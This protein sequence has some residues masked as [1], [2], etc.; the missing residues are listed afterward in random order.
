MCWLYLRTTKETRKVSNHYLRKFYS[1]G[2]DLNPDGW[3][4][5]THMAKINDFTLMKEPVNASNSMV[6]HAVG[7]QSGL[8]KTRATIA[9]VRKMSVGVVSY[10]NTQ[11]MNII[12]KKTGQPWA[13]AHN[14]TAEIN[15]IEAL[16]K[17]VA[18]NCTYKPVTDLDSERLFIEFLDCIDR[19]MPKGDESKATFNTIHE[20]FE[21]LNDYAK[22]C[23]VATNG[24]LSFAYRDLLGRR[25]LYLLKDTIGY[26]VCTKNITKAD[27]KAFLPGQLLVFKKGEIIYNSHVSKKGVAPK[28]HKFFSTWESQKGAPI[29]PSSKWDFA[30]PE[31]EYLM[32]R[33]NFHDVAEEMDLYQDLDEAT[34]SDG[35]RDYG[36][37]LLQ[38]GEDGH[39]F[40]DY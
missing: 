16:N 18:E 11:P 38:E 24:E 13:F 12:S 33:D 36:D 4:I 25:K 3:G 19:I 17:D 27:W 10:K 5:T 35:R 7:I 14:G 9:H 39:Y 30:F 40:H 2:G 31:N 26:V 34:R 8:P 28:V 37:R 21:T 20:F 32:G 6:A 29:Y 22:M 15:K 23:I 1:K